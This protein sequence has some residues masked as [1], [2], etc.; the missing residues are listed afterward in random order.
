MTAKPRKTDAR[1]SGPQSL[2]IPRQNGSVREVFLFQ[3]WLL[4]V[5][6]FR[7]SCWTIWG[8]RLKSSGKEQPDWLKVWPYSDG[9]QSYSLL[10]LYYYLNR[11]I[12]KPSEVGR[13]RPSG[14]YKKIFRE[15]FENWGSQAHI[16]KS[17]SV[18]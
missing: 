4:T 11:A 9:G 3:E 10:K 16:K 15:E 13:K 14:Y 5:F 8:L 2:L 6:V 17:L 7:N 18:L 12:A 1:T